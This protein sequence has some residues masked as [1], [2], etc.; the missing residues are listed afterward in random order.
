MPTPSATWIDRPSRSGAVVAIAA[1]WMQLVVIPI[2][3][4]LIMPDEAGFLLNTRRLGAGAP[5]SGLD[6]FPG[7]SALITPFASATASPEALTTIVQVINGVL[8]VSAA[9]LAMALARRLH[10][11]LSEAAIAGIGVVTAAYPAYRLFAAFALSENLLVPST[12]LLVLLF[13]RLLRRA[14]PIDGLVFGLFAGLAF[15]IHARA[16]AL[17]LAALIAALTF[18]RGR[19]LAA[20]LTGLAAGT[21]ASVALV[22]FTVDSS[23]DTGGPRTSA[24]TALRDAGSVNG[25]LDVASSAIGQVFYLLVATVGIAG[26]GGWWFADQL[27]NQRGISGHGQANRTTA[28]VAVLSILILFGSLGV[29]SLF[30]AGGTGDLAIYGRYGE[31]VLL[32]FLVA[33]LVQISGLPHLTNRRAALIA[34]AILLL[35]GLLLATRGPEAFDGRM[36]LLNIAGVFPI[37]DTVG[38]IRL[39]IIGLAGVAA[40]LIAATASRIRPAL[41]LTVVVLGFLWTSWFSIERSAAAIEIL[42]GQDELVAVLEDLSGTVD[43]VALDIWQLPD[44]WHQENYRLTVNRQ[45]FRYWSSAAPEEPC[46]DL[47]ISRR[48][49]L[50]DIVPGAAVVAVE[51]FGQQALWVLPGPTMA[52]VEARLGPPIEGPLDPLPP[53]QMAIVKLETDVTTTSPAGLL[54]LVVVIENAGPGGLFPEFGFADVLGSVNIGVELRP[55]D[56]PDVRVHEPIRIRLTAALGPEGRMEIARR[57]RPIDIQPSVEPGSYVMVASLVQ[58]GIAW[59]DFDA[60]VAIEIT[61]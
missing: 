25:L 18:V 51:P 35:A 50:D 37:V 15:S 53:N 26:L 21:A 57:L 19:Q 47:V 30:L 46:S 55:A 32:P 29:S 45:E 10:P 34:M 52:A 7:Y 43:C 9:L 16:V 54:D 24:G 8:L 41:G 4:P 20:S 39:S 14:T 1:F 23:V 38:D 2:R 12:I 56:E 59:T 28:G 22:A 33:G 60:S 3:R 48:A 44:R 31:G 11:E 40:I 42:D 17:T 61:S 27:R 49:D 13:E 5:P 6:Y 58:E 36:L